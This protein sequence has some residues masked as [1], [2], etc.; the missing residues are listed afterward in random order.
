MTTVILYR[1]ERENG[2]GMYRPGG[3]NDFSSPFNDV[4]D[5][6][7]EH[8]GEDRKT[9]CAAHCKIHMIPQDDPNLS[10]LFWGPTGRY[11]H[12]AFASSEQLNHWIYR[13]E[14]KIG[15]RLKGYAVSIYSVDKEFCKHGDTQSV[16]MKSNARLID[17]VDLMEF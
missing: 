13:H 10:F 4:I 9:Y 14:W 2:D 3:E 6:W 12:F 5:E 15:L 17:R 8:S 16:F 7:I 1:V 11:Y